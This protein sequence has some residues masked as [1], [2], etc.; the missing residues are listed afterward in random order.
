LTRAETIVGLGARTDY[1]APVPNADPA[2]LRLTAEEGALF[3]QVGRAARID[4]LL[5]RSGL[6]EPK[7][8]S[9]L[10]ALRAKGAIAPARVSRQVAEPVDAALAE[11][12]EI[13]EERKREI[14][15]MERLLERD[16]FA[17]LG[18][19]PMASQEQLRDAFFEAS[20]KFHPD[21]FYGKNLGSFRARIDRIFQ[22]L[23]EAHA[24][25]SDPGRRQA[26][27]AVHPELGA[28][29]VPEPSPATGASAQAGLVEDGRSVER[30]ARLAKH[31]YLAKQTRLGEL[32]GRGRARLANGEAS[33]AV[34]D[35]QVAAQL[36][37]QNK[38]LQA[39]LAEAKQRA[40]AQRAEQE[41]E[42][43]GQAELLG[44]A[45]MAAE[46]YKAAAA[47]DPRNSTAAYKAAACL[48]RLGREAREV[49][50]LALRA[51][52]LSP[53]SAEAQALLGE[54]YLEAGMKKLAKKHLD[55]ALRLRPDHAEAKRVLKKLRWPF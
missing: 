6:E 26:Y 40:D 46:A 41:L 34:S 5:S 28:T 10:L 48:H 23:A 18:L 19:S 3:A 11:E 47:L 53:K 52:E 38:E 30:R 14:L 29:A 15:Q 33:L 37:P 32:V 42:R 55:E 49:H 43:A 25:L 16:H 1:V 45:A 54:I 39:M 7:A 44:N 35:L 20:R 31:P 8:I 17:V 21:R 12:V 50:G 36:D 13:S 22:R 4:E 2:R 51:V 9:V 27:L 24:T